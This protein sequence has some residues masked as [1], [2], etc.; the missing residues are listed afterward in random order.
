MATSV[1]VGVV[2][3]DL[4]HRLIQDGQGRLK[5][6]ENA[7]SVMTSIDNIL[8]TSQGERVMLPAFGGN[9]RAVLFENITQTMMKVLSRQVKDTIEAW[10]DRVAIQEVELQADPDRSTVSITIAFSIRGHGNI[11]EFKTSLG[12][13]I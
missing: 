12:S 3:S 7:A 4:D 6:V 1:K 8:R 13:T 10:D 11:F 9:L 5:L 2:W